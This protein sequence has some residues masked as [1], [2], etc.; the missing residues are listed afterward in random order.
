VLASADSVFLQLGALTSKSK[1]TTG[2]TKRKI[3]RKNKFAGGILPAFQRSFNEHTVLI[4]E[5]DDLQAERVIMVN[6][7]FAQKFFLARTR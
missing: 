3:K 7:A 2:S 5:R 6:H 1:T 4:S